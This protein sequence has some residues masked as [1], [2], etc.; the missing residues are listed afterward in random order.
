MRSGA[1][2]RSQFVSNFKIDSTWLAEKAPAL[3]SRRCEELFIAH[4]MQNDRRFPE[5]PEKAIRKAFESNKRLLVIH[6]PLLPYPYGTHHTKM[7]VLVYPDGGVRVVV[8]SAS[9][10]PVNVDYSAEVAWHQDFAPKGP[11][12]APT[13]EFEE[14]LIAYLESEGMHEANAGEAEGPWRR[15]LDAVRACDFACAKAHLVTSVPGIHGGGDVDRYGHMRVRRLLAQHAFPAKFKQAPICCQSSSLGSMTP[16]VSARAWH[17]IQ[18]IA[19]QSAL[20]WN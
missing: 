7:F 10:C 19:N 3:A 20:S 9:L 2:R 11:G 14:D 18:R 4:G 1:T 5:G 17:P 12:A 6:M 16:D 13:S 15:F 8:S